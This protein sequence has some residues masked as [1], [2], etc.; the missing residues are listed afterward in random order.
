MVEEIAAQVF[1]RP[2]L[3]SI[4]RYLLHDRLT[5]H[6]IATKWR[7]FLGKYDG[8]LIGLSGDGRTYAATQT[9]GSVVEL[10]DRI[11]GLRE[12]LPMADGLA[13]DTFSLSTDGR[14][15]AFSPYRARGRFRRSMSTTATPA[16]ATACPARGKR[17]SD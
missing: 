11:S 14:Y 15:T 1:T 4:Q 13:Y 3:P 9:F 10:V 6:T 16:M 12:P 17:P 8:L 5:G 7:D 2:V